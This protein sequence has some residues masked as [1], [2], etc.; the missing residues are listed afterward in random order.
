MTDV[1]RTLDGDQA[2]MSRFLDM[3]SRIVALERDATR[4]Y[5]GPLNYIRNG[6]FNVWQRGPGAFGGNVYNADGFRTFATGTTVSVTR[7]AFTLGNTIAGQ[8]PLYYHRNVVTSSAGAGNFAVLW[9]GIEGVRSLAGQTATLSF[10]AKADAAKN[11][12]VEFDQ[13]FGAGGSPSATVTG[14][15]VQKLALTTG[16]RR[17]TVTVS[18]PSIA[19]KTLGTDGS[20]RLAVNF[21]LDA[22]STYNARTASLGQQSGTFEFWGVQ[23]E[24]GATAT[25]FDRR[26]PALD[27]AENQR[28]F[29]R[30]FGTNFPGLAIGTTRAF[31]TIPL[32]V[33]MRTPPAWSAGTLATLLLWGTGAGGSTLSTCSI[34]D[35]NTDRVVL[36]AVCGAAVLLDGGG[37]LLWTNGSY[38]DFVA[39]L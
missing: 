33:T 34:W 29:W 26:P 25:D 7:Q 1:G 30:C 15:G 28:Y 19:G 38:M 3:Q 22:G 27:L 4:A 21:W 31:I 37:A 2:F 18:I 10:W 11:I 14:I 24:Q 17:Y 36:D 5:R 6:A 13:Y 32:P 23:L 16:W 9:Q 8:E 39:E 35:E 20:D 12:A